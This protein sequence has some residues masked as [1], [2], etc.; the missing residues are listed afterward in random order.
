MRMKKKMKVL[1]VLFA[2]VILLGV[3]LVPRGY[4]D[5]A[6]NV[7]QREGT[8]FVVTGS[9]DANITNTEINAYVTNTTITI[10]PE[11]GTVFEIKPATGV[12]FNITGDVNATIQG[13]ASVSI[14]YATITVDVATIRER[15]SEENRLGYGDNIGGVDPGSDATVTLFNN[16]LGTTV[17]VELL[18]AIIYRDPSETS[19]P[20]P[21]DVFGSFEFYDSDGVRFARIYIN[22]WSDV[23]NLD[24]A[25][26]LPANGYVKLKVSNRGSVRAAFAGSVVYR[27]P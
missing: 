22:F 4:P 18:T 2:L 19:S 12:T 8:T 6:L 24:P 23:K 27:K 10:T 13:T 14:D 3:V 17:Y 21:K 11:A 15:A 26:P 7:M 25:I 9:V 16:T 20:D 1:L 5:W